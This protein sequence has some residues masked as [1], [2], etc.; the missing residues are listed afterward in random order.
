MIRDQ[1]G[2]S[3]GASG[4]PASSNAP[5]NSRVRSQALSAQA[6]AV[7]GSIGSALS[8]PPPTLR[9]DSNRWRAGDPSLRELE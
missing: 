9:S 6:R 7:D 4:E 1:S 8:C 5:T 2:R 3:V